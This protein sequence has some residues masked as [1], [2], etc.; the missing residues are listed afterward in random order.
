MGKTRREFLK[1]VGVGTAGLAV[2]GLPFCRTTEPPPDRP[3][4]LLIFTDQHKL[5]AAGCYGP[6]PCQTPHID[7]LAASGVRFETAY[8]SCPVCS[9]ARASMMTGFYPHACGVT[10]CNVPLPADLVAM[11]GK[12]HDVIVTPGGFF[13]YVTVVGV[14]GDSDF[15]VQFNGRTFEELGRA[16]V[17]KDPHVSL[18]PR[19][20]YLYVPAQDGDVVHVLDRYTME[21]VTDIS[22]PGA[23]GAAMRSDGR[24]FYTTNISGGGDDALWV[25]DT[26]A[27]SVDAKVSLGMCW[28]PTASATASEID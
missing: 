14:A 4:I 18:T 11:G 27:N 25:I 3:N 12:P 22:V 20:P 6:T 7:R 28:T 1:T 15:V 16:A 2:S 17:A 19:N 10:R 8:T 23:H 13:A 9:P 21:A 26:T 24:Y 5:S